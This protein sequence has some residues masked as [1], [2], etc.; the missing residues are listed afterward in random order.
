M[1][2]GWE[3]LRGKIECA[4]PSQ[5]VAERVGREGAARQP[6]HPVI[7]SAVDV[8]GHAKIPDLHHQVV[9]HQAVTGGQ[10]TVDKVEGGEI[11]HARSDLRG[12]LQ[13]VAQRQLPAGLP[14]PLVQDLGVG[15]VRPARAEGLLRA[16]D[17][18]HTG[19][20]GQV[21]VWERECKSRGRA[22]HTHA[23]EEVHMCMH[24]GEGWV[25][26]HVH[27]C[28]QAHRGRACTCAREGCACVCMHKG[29]ACT[30]VRACQG[31]VCTSARMHRGK[32]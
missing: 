7:V 22:A 17:K 32:G 12:D 26:A 8:P 30:C 31:R 20:G 21:C 3:Q 29:K 4:C 16:G 15:A 24:T 6:T 23:R 25:H 14:L 18:T 19:V 28:V 2:V 9:A 5:P 10:V 27:V 13:H 1:E 11:D